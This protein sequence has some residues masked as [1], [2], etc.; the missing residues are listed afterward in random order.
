MCISDPADP[1]EAVGAAESKVVVD[2]PNGSPLWRDVR[3]ANAG[4]LETRIDNEDAVD[5]IGE[6]MP[7]RWHLDYWTDP[8]LTQKLRGL[9]EG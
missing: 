8:V 6:G 7:V 1:A 9:D 2:A 4:K 3:T 5:P